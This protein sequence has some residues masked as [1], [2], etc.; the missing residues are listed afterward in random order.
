MLVTG[1]T[2]S[3]N[4]KTVN[5]ARPQHKGGVTDAFAL[6]IALPPSPPTSA[7]ASAPDSK[8]VVVTWIDNSLDETYFFVE[9]RTGQTG[10]YAA[11]ARISGLSG[12]LKTAKY[13]DT[14]VVGGNLYQYRIRAQSAGGYSSYRETN[15]VSVLTPPT[16]LA[17]VRGTGTQVKLTWIA[18][19][20]GLGFIGYEVYRKTGTGAYARI[21][22]AYGT[23]FTD[24]F[25]QART[26]YSYQVRAT[27]FNSFSSLS[28]TATVTTP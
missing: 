11:L 1:S 12:A 6:Q 24:T 8:Q 7:V 19:K 14:A 22:M 18:S 4:F 20:G 3:T 15:Q 23:T 26:T 21:A 5:A 17:A 16:N 28:N 2:E 27:S 10:A 13:V 9:R 25:T